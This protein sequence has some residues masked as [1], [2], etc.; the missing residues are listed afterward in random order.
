ML[1][2]AVRQHPCAHGRIKL[3]GREPDE[4]GISGSIL[5]HVDLV[6]RLIVFALDIGTTEVVV[7]GYPPSLLGEWDTIWK[8]L[9]TIVA[10][11]VSSV[12]D[13]R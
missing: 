2:S 6:A 8:P 7:F 5:P 10:S 3:C 11:L 9:G 12:P 13:M 1:C 4:L